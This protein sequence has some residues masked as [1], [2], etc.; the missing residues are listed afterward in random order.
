MKISPFSAAAAV[1]SFALLLAPL[2][3]SFAQAP[4][5]PATTGVPQEGISSDWDVKGKML[6]LANDV[7]RIEDL[8]ARTR[9]NEWVAKGAPEAY[10]QQLESCKSSFQLLL[11]SAGKLAKDPE[12]LSTALETL[13][14]M[15]SMDSLLTSLQGGIRRYQGPSLADDIMRFVADNSR[16]RDVL[17]QHS[18]DLAAARENEFKV[19]HS[20]AQ[21]CRA[22]LARKDAPEMQQSRPVVRRRSK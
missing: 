18:V 8:L 19:I 17:R 16:H 14:R 4:S 15:D 11:E 9:P 13:F 5:A 3:C 2:A 1:R 10:I 12:R 22:E 21:R 6:A 7:A 20:E